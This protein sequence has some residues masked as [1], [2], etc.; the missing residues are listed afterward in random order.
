MLTVRGGRFMTGRPEPTEYAAYYEKYIS[1]VPEGDLGEMLARQIDESL[2]VYR[3][4]SEE[5]SRFRY[6][7]GKWSIKQA[8]GH[9]ADTERVFAY[10]AF[11]FA[12]GEKAT[13][14]SFEQDEY[15]ALADSDARTWTSLIEELKSVRAGSVSLFRSLSDEALM[16]QGIA[17][18]N[19]VTVRALGFMI[20]GHER[21][22]LSILKERY[23]AAPAYAGRT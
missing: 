6:E 8:L 22:H 11:A 23:L 17:S 9:V 13:L 21:Y 3:G 7:P 1:L 19:P 2:T 16:R 18:N 5:Q 20:A 14:A 12:R 15:A 10:R 4:V